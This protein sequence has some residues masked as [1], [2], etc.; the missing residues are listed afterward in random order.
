MNRADKYI[1]S[2]HPVEEQQKERYDASYFALYREDPRR[3]VMYRAE[4]ER[5]EHHKPAGG[6]ILDVGCGIGAF[7]SQ[8]P[9]SRWSR[10]GT[11]ISELAV[12]EARARGIEVKDYASAYDYPREF[13]DV[14]VF[15]GSLQ[16]ITTPFSTIQRCIA[17]LAPGGFL[18]FLST[19]NSNSPYYRRFKTLPFLTPH[20]NFLIP[21]DI[22][23]RDALQNFGLQVVEIRYPY[24]GG[25]YARPIRDHLLYVLSFFGLKRKFAF[26]RSS[27]E[28]YARKPERS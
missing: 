20:A 2:V 7:L 5:I 6:R 23:M 27:M 24:L 1:Q 12:R 26:W 11:D 10:F 28:I 9:V 14:I 3:L 18:V 19:P 4:R 8:F 13:F 25:P 16:L 17:L 15:R 22:M 21:S